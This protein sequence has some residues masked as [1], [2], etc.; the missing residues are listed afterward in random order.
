VLSDPEA[1]WRAIPPD[2]VFSLFQAKS[3]CV[4]MDQTSL[5]LLLSEN[6]VSITPLGLLVMVLPDWVVD[7]ETR[8]SYTSIIRLVECCRE[9]HWEKDILPFSDHAIDSTVKMINGEFKKPIPVGQIILIK[10][11]I[12]QVRK[13]SYSLQFSVEDATNNNLYAIINLVSVFL[14]PTSGSTYYPSKYLIQILKAKI[15]PPGVP[16]SLKI[17][18]S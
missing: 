5:K 6:G 17:D 11:N 9:Y 16:G 3:K 7:N 13:K 8:L 15:N 1:K 10:Y 18:F 2:M 14:D 12:V 4:K